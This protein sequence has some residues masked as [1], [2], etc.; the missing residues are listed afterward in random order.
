MRKNLIILMISL[1]TLFLTYSCDDEKSDKCSK[2]NLTG[3]CDGELICNAGE[4]VAKGDPCSASSPEG[5][6]EG[7]LIC[8][9]G[10]CID[11]NNAC[12]AEKPDGYCEDNK[13]CIDGACKSKLSM[14]RVGFVAQTIDTD[15]HP[16]VLLDEFKYYTVDL[17]GRRKQTLTNDTLTCINEAACWSSPNMKFFLYLVDAGDDTYTLKIA[18]NNSGSV[19]FA[20]AKVITEKFNTMIGVKFLKTNAFIYLKNKIITNSD[21]KQEMI[22]FIFKYDMDSKTSTELG[23][24]AVEGTVQDQ[25]GNDVAVHFA[26]NNFILSGDGK[27]IVFSIDHGYSTPQ[28]RKLAVEVYKMD[29]VAL[30]PAEKI[31]EYAR[32]NLSGSGIKYGVITRDN[33]KVIFITT[34]DLKHRVHVINLDG[35]SL[36][37]AAT[38][39]PEANPLG[40]F[41]GPDIN[42]C[43]D[44]V[45][46]QICEV[47]SQLYI[48][49]DNKDVYFAGKVEK[50]TE[51]SVKANLYKFNI[52]NKTLTNITLGTAL[53]DNDLHSIVFNMDL[54]IVTYLTKTKYFV[55]DNTPWYIDLSDTESIDEITGLKNFGATSIILS[56]DAKELKVEVL[57]P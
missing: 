9:A 39:D 32:V 29:L 34:A 25:D 45:G 57:K 52:E 14:Y 51:L 42:A 55:K 56:K 44:I 11:K 7:G 4:C 31:Y 21:G 40:E 36:I 17:N 20:H 50:L 49:K 33:S 24:F 23:K 43:S 27:Y 22:P 37:D 3:V 6:C 16:S 48:S 19:D 47:L 8:E 35:T 53:E 12:S 1:V 38:Q 5:Y 15:S 26:G 30:T 46:T 28:E 10:K 13:I 18:D 54:N 2:D 41:I